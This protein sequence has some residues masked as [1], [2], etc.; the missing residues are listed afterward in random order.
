MLFSLSLFH[1]AYMSFGSDLVFL[2][3]GIAGHQFGFSIT[4]LDQLQKYESPI[5]EFNF[6]W[7]SKRFTKQ[8]AL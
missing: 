3:L 2:K 6:M 7:F 1:R 8:F 4:L 5:L